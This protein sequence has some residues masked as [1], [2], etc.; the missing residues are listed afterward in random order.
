M[1]MLFALLVALGFGLEKARQRKSLAK[2]APP[3]SGQEVPS[4]ELTDLAGRAISARSLRGQK[5]ALLFFNVGCSACRSELQELNR[6]LP[7]FPDN[8]TVIP[9]SLNTFEE[10]M[11]IKSEWGLD[12]DLY[13]AANNLAREMGVK[14]V[15]SLILVDEAGRI[16]HA[17]TG[18]LSR[19]EQD[20]IFQRFLT[21]RSF[22][23]GE[24]R[25]SQTEGKLTNNSNPGCPTQ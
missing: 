22:S 2:S 6:L 11:M 8:F 24:S 10:T 4:F 16:Q 9:A 25:D 12:F 15:P 13:P 19:A 23:E 20:F 17:R 18:Y 1:V 21:G 14:M 3:R 5:F 7:A